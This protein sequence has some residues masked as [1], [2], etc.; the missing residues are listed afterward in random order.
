MMLEDMKL[1][2]TPNKMMVVPVT[3]RLAATVAIRP[4]VM[5]APNIEN[6]ADD[7]TFKIVNGA[8]IK[9]DRVAPTAA[10]PETPSVKGLARGL[11]KS[12]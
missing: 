6:T 11:R 8:D 7:L 1:S 9:R 3:C 12:A 5:S 4:A 10:P 2:T